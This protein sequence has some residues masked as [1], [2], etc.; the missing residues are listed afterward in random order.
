VLD[1]ACGSGH[2]LL[3]AFDL[4]HTIYTEAWSD[5][6]L[7]PALW[8]V[9]GW[10]PPAHAGHDGHDTESRAVLHR[11]MP[12]F[13]LRH[14]L[15]GID[16]DLRSTQIAG[17]ALWLRA[18]RAY[19]DAD[20]ERNAR[21]KITRANLVCAE[22][23][24]GEADLL[25]EFTAGLKPVVLGSLARA[26]FEKMR[27]AGDAGSLLK[28]EQE[29]RDSISDAKRRWKQTPREEQLALWPE[30][31]PAKGIQIEQGSLF[32]ITSVTDDSFW[33]EAEERLREALQ[34]Y[35][36]ST[37]GPNMPLRRLFAEDAA[38]GFGFFDVCRERFDVVLMNPPFGETSKPSKAY[39]EQAY[40]R[41][42][43]DVYAAFM[44]RGRPATPA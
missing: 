4:L 42:K 23:M 22:P 11:A 29:M 13:I 10:T 24:P 35:A 39:I 27:L 19:H 26:I 44:E 18:Q 2:F 20:I 1:P 36:E 43:H 5:P 30:H 17:L 25:R 15:H 7:G 41:S 37:V 8:R 16:I 28:I 32:D 33:E 9:L 38:Q 31:T 34:S 14:N 21:P 3:Y 6:D 12:G 40:P